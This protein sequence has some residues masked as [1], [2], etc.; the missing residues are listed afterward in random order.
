V[1]PSAAAVRA[2]LAT[3]PGAVAYLPVD[4]VDASCRVLLTL[5][6]GAR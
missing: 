5:E 4:E 6:P 2:Y 3:E 1:L